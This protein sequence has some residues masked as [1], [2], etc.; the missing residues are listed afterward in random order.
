MC[1]HA[2]KQH[3]SAECGQTGN[4]HWGTVTDIQMLAIAFNV[5]FIIFPMPKDGDPGDP[6]GWV[7]GLEL[8]RGDFSHW[9]LLYCISNVHF[10]LF[11][12]QCGRG[13]SYKSVY[14]IEALP[15]PL[16]Q[17]YNLNNTAAPVGCAASVNFL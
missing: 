1:L 6:R 4:N 9:M 13:A 3:V 15:A 8:D 17:Q 10:Q 11:F 5:G 7:K 12:L 14:P 16:Q 2:L